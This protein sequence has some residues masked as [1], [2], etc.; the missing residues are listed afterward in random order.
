LTTKIQALFRENI[1]QEW[2]PEQIKGRL[3]IKGI[4][5]VCATTIYGFIQKDK[6]SGGELHKY[7]RHRKAYKKRTGS[8]ETRGQIIGR[9]SIDERPVI[10]D[11]KVR[12]G[13]WEADT[14]IGKGHQGVLVTLADRVSKKTLI[15]QVP[16]KHADV[17]TDAIVKL[18][19]PEKKHLH[20]ITFDNGKEFAYHAQ[21]KKALGA[22][23]YFAHPYH[24][25]ERG[26]NENHNGLIRQYL[27]KSM[28][29]DKV[30]DE[31]VTLIQ[32]KLNNR[33]RK[34]LGYKTPN[35]VYDAMCLV[36]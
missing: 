32:D 23:N 21:I 14:V 5:M 8:S 6:A 22:D 28:A 4:P 16:S 31:E 3:K 27:P 13:D 29:L 1:Q 18:L 30:T 20:T 19:L 10:V 2:S 11:K 34:L 12:I 36:A 35:E 26:L 25:W 24:S 33:P 17:V 9:I 7:L 15:A